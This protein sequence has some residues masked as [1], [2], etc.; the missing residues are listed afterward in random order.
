MRPRERALLDFLVANEGRTVS[1]EEILR[2][3]WGVDFV[4][5]TA[6]VAVHVCWLRK[7]IMSHTI[8]TVRGCG[9]RLERA[10]A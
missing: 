6:T 9:Y 1:H 2:T 5:E 3:V 10:I 7:K 8:K 4:G